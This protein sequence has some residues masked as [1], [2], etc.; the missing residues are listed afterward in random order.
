M[1]EISRVEISCNANAKVNL[2]LHVVGQREDGYHLL[3]SLVCFAEESDSLH[4]TASNSKSKLI[5]LSVAG[6]FV[7]DL[8]LDEHNLV[9][10][11]AHFLAE[12]LS[13]NS[14]HCSPVAIK[15]EKNLPVAS[16]IGGGSADAAAALVL[17]KE[18]WAK[19]IAVDLHKIA[20]ELGAD[21]PM[22]LDTSPKRITGTGE[23]QAKFPLEIS[24]PILLVNPGILVPTPQIF[25][26][27]LNKH[28]PPIGTSPAPGLN[29]IES[30]VDL[31]APLRNDL[32]APAIAVNPQIATVLHEIGAQPGCELSRMSG[33][34]ATCFGLFE[35]SASAK[36]A[37][38]KLK[39]KY[40]N[41]WC[42]WT[43]TI[44]CEGLDHG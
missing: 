40:P 9:V 26:A 22:C 23:I 30:V 6:D 37:Q 24:L 11:A 14:I 21:V 28:Q 27:L 2:A 36:H 29:N 41:W 17:L 34:G 3:D 7:G 44:A 35:H 10:K 32:E 8:G 42:V 39:K 38:A 18:Y 15:L 31:L 25:S 13:G 5:S 43:N 20:F 19:D 1:P 12:E 16:G 33:S 4:L